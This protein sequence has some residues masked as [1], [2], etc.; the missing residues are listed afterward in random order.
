VVAAQCR[1]EAAV[2]RNRPIEVG[3]SWTHSPTESERLFG[4][5]PVLAGRSQTKPHYD[6]GPRVRPHYSLH[7]V[8]AGRAVF[9]SDSMER[10]VEVAA[11]DLFCIFP[12]AITHQRAV[13]ADPPRLTWI[14]FD[15]PAAPAVADRLGLA[16]EQPVLRGLDLDRLRPHLRRAGSVLAE[17]QTGHPL[18]LTEYL[19]GFLG[20]LMAAAPAAPPPRRESWLRAGR[21]LIEEHCTEIVSVAEVAKQVGVDR[22]H[23]S[24][25]F[26]REFG[27]SPSAHLQEA[28]LSEA[29]RL[30]TETAL[31]VGQVAQSVGYADVYSFSHAFRRV[32]GI[33]PSQARQS[34]AG[35]AGTNGPNPPV[36]SRAHTQ[37]S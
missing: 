22:S 7:I 17:S 25:E 18:R 30:L 9:R 24:K 29:R 13:R 21:S 2:L 1:R 14:A 31:S 3:E 10:D 5:W 33:S 11:G 36:G 32:T 37:D 26:A 16:P 6:V 34:L 15:G 35:K 28:R 8:L 27:R 4:V 19:V 23:F 20:E 12:D